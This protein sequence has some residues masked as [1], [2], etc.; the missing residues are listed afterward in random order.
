MNELAMFMN[1]TKN[2]VFKPAINEYKGRFSFVGS[3]P[4]SLGYWDKNSI[5]QEI[6]RSNIYNSRQ[7]AEEALA[8]VFNN[9]GA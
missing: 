7:E 2:R 6:F 1:G 8:K 5:G 9:K 4:E 3:I